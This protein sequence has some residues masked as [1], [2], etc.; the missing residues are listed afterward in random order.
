MH[1][2]LLVV[3]LFV[4]VRACTR[5]WA[6]VCACV[7]GCVCVRVM[8]VLEWRHSAFVQQI[9]LIETA[10]EWQRG[11]A[12]AGTPSRLGHRD[13]DKKEMGAACLAEKVKR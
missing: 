10:N 2:E 3:V 7:C 1:E 5:V 12:R 11:T 13:R 8:C 6:C 4:C 9:Y